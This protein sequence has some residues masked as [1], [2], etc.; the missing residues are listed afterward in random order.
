MVLAAGP[1]G[2]GFPEL[3]IILVVVLLIFGASRLADLGG[4]LGTSIREFR[5]AANDPE[6]ADATKSATAQASDA[7]A[8]AGIH[9]AKCGAEIEN[10]DVKFCPSC[11]S[12]VQAAV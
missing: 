4:A 5:R 9:C 7:P 11:G 3:L 6:D 10:R 1:F 2:L 8:T 12:A